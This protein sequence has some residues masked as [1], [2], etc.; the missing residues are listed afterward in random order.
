M[1]I[2]ALAAGLGLLVAAC[3]LSTQGL[4]TPGSAPAPDAAAPGL[5]AGPRAD[6]GVDVEEAGDA[7]PSIDAAVEAGPLVRYDCNGASTASC[8]TCASKPIGCVYCTQGGGSPFAGLC[9]PTNELCFNNVPNGYRVCPCNFPNASMCP[10]DG[11][12]CRNYT[13]Q[14]CTTCGDPNSDGSPCKQGGTCDRATRTCN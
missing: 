4:G 6:G 3:G 5:D 13:P 14:Y 2:V 1:R 11:Q 8:A 10:V 9:L 7:R 12:A